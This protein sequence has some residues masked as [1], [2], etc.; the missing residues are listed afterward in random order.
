MCCLFLQWIILSLCRLEQ[1]AEQN[2]VRA[3][4]TNQKTICLYLDLFFSL[5]YTVTSIHSIHWHSVLTGKEQRRVCT[6]K[7]AGARKR[8]SIA[9]HFISA[10]CIRLWKCIGRVFE[11]KN[12]QLLSTPTGWPYF[13]SPEIDTTTSRS[14]SLSSDSFNLLNIFV[15]VYVWIVQELGRLKEE[16]LSVG[17]WRKATQVTFVSPC[18]YNW[19]VLVAHILLLI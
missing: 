18:F 8:T 13:S 16:K 19:F 6:T 7:S 3:V 10:Y 5:I 12:I 1:Q 17:M 2:A 9:M 11:F 14:P 4:Q 15:G